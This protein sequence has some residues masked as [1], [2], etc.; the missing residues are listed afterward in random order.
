MF[1]HEENNLFGFQNTDTKS[2]IL[3]ELA[4]SAKDDALRE[5]NFD[6]GT[7][8]ERML[9]PEVDRQSGDKLDTILVGCD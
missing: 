4:R 1:F 8:V 3:M 5:L 7:R 6:V 2:N 9:G